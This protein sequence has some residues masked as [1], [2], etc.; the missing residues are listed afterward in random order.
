MAFGECGGGGGGGGFM[1][2]SCGGWG[3]ETLGGRG[4]CSDAGVRL[5]A[6]GGGSVLWIVASHAPSGGGGRGHEATHTELPNAPMTQA[7]SQSSEKW[8][9]STILLSTGAS[10]GNWIFFFVKDRP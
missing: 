1:M 5:C 3:A 2:R 10:F 9:C 8:M 6:G 7:C 4:G